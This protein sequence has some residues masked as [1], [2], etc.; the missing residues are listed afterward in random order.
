MHQSGAYCQVLGVFFWSGLTWFSWQETS[1]W[2][3]YTRQNKHVHIDSQTPET[4]TNMW[5]SF[6]LGYSNPNEDIWSHDC[7]LWGMRSEIRVSKVPVKMQVSP[8]AWTFQDASCSTNG[9]HR[10][11]NCERP[12]CK[13]SDRNCWL[14]V[15]LIM[16]GR[17]LIL[18]CDLCQK[19]F[20]ENLWWCVHAAVLD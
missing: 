9:L 16:L 6:S 17:V 20:F 14:Q 11:L 5:L 13:M 8:Q 1:S 7:H 19:R 12:L 3:E 10:T 4:W 15:L 18:V 2:L